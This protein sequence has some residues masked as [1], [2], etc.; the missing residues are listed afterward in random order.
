MLNPGSHDPSGHIDVDYV[1]CEVQRV[2]GTSTNSQESARI[3]EQE[4]NLSFLRSNSIFVSFSIL[5][6]FFGAFL[7]K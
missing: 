5:F 3:D 7:Q 2:A 1:I 6:F 4:L